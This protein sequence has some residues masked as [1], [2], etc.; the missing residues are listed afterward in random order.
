MRRQHEDKSCLEEEVLIAEGVAPSRKR[1][2][3]IEDAFRSISISQ[4]HTNPVPLP[5]PVGGR[6]SVV[7]NDDFMIDAEDDDSDDDDE[8]PL[9]EKEIAEREI[10]R[11]LVYGL[12][13]TQPVP[14]QDPVERMLQDLIRGSIREAITRQ[15]SLCDMD[16]ETSYNRRSATMDFVEQQRRPRSNSLPNEFPLDADAAMDMSPM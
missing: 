10:M 3:T 5:V 8:N 15:T 14:R 1:R 12:R 11:A 6:L 7:S 13:P 2:R 9:T 16:V 4:N